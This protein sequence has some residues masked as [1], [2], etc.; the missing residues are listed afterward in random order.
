[1]KSIFYISKHAAIALLLAGLF[2][3]E[4]NEENEPEVNIPFT[5][6]SL[7]EISYLSNLAY[8]D[9]VIVVNSNEDLVKCIHQFG[10]KIRYPAIDFS[11]YTLLLASGAADYG[12]VD[13]AGIS[14]KILTKNYRLRLQYR[15]K[16]RQSSVYLWETAALIPKLPQDAQISLEFDY[17]DENIDM[18]QIDF[19]NIGDLY[20]QPLPVIQKA[21]SGKWEVTRVCFGWSG[22]QP[23]KDFFIEFSANQRTYFLNGGTSSRSYSWRKQYI[24]EN[25][26][27]IPTYVLWYNDSNEELRLECY[28]FRWISNNQLRSE[29]GSLASNEAHTVIHYNRIY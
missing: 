13:I 10:D 29:T 5:E 27:I 28:R 15:Q 6:Y 19:S 7:G 14:Q 22:C 25:G 9:S 18:S 11:K 16:L 20:R 17:K 24:R 1:M 12:I 2:A 3:C 8:D 26:Q 23:R 21:I 4:E